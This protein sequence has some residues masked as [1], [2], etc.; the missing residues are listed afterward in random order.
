MSPFNLI[1]SE[2]RKAVLVA[3]VLLALVSGVFL[4]TLNY[5][6]VTTS[7]GT[8]VIPKTSMSLS[9]TFVDV[10]GWGWTDL[11]THRETVSAMVRAGYAS[12]IPQVERFNNA[13]RAGIR[14]L[15]EFYQ[16][17]QEGVQRFDEHL[18]PQ[19]GS[20]PNFMCS[21]FLGKPEDRCKRGRVLIFDLAF[22]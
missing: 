22:L 16:K 12:E 9:D 5:H 4:F 19:R 21:G 6:V 8:I 18:R 10:R 11:W 14:T 2:A 1:R 13:I 3:M 15:E 7:K 17:M 20:S